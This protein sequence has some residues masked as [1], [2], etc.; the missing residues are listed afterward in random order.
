MAQTG[1]RMT[2]IECQ[3]EL[4]TDAFPVY[5]QKG[6]P[7]RLKRCRDCVNRAKREAY[8]RKRKDPERWAELQQK[9]A[10]YH[11]RRTED[12]QT[13]ADINRRH[14]ETQ[15]ARLE[16]KRKDPE[17]WAAHL[18]AERERSRRQRE[19]LAQ[20]PVAWRKFND[21]R[22]RKTVARRQWL[23]RNRPAAYQAL[24][25]RHRLAHYDWLVRNGLPTPDPDRRR[26]GIELDDRDFD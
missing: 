5:N 2:C 14:R 26:R 15:R 16:R 18:E 22:N 6:T 7:Y 23:K 9:R 10:A 12:P 19:R 4:D 24:I 17:L 13:R 21:E 8:A 25:E 3:R 1:G 20:D 11:R